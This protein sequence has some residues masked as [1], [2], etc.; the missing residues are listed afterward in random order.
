MRR[1]SRLAVP[2]RRPEDVIP[3]LGARHHWKQGHSAKALADFWWGA[4]ALP[5]PIRALLDQAPPVAGAELI[6]GW[7]E[8]ETDLLD[9]EARASQTDLLAL[10]GVGDAL[11]V[12]GVEAKAGETFGPTVFAKLSDCSTGV[13]NRVE[14]LCQHLGL[15]Y[16]AAQ[17]LRYQLLHRTVAT[18]LEAKRFRASKA[19]LLV[20]SFRDDPAGL[21]DYQRFVQSIGFPETGTGTLEGP[22]RFGAVDL[23][24]GWVDSDVPACGLT[25][26]DLRRTTTMSPS[27]WEGTLTD[28]RP[29][30]IR[31]RWGQ[32]SI[33]IGR[34]GQSADEAAGGRVWL[35]GAVGE[36]T[37]PIIEL[38]QVLQ[39]T[40]LVLTPELKVADL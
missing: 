40:G 19:V 18:L 33:R 36:D 29:L 22:R 13:Q 8:R 31:Y 7:L 1:S 35:E 6:D 11:A 32:L 24:T 17:S 28:G 39:A 38:P 27:Q 14:Q 25:I 20:Q 16:E 4:T 5:A 15:E 9:S 2:L 12:L 26:A 10:L 23:W 34:Q 21:E 3:H 37:S 30:Y